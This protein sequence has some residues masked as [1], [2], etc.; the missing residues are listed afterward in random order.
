MIK[1]FLLPT[2]LALLS[3]SSNIYANECPAGGVV[4]YRFN[5]LDTTHE[6]FN[7][8]LG[9]KLPANKQ[10][11][12]YNYAEMTSGFDLR[13]TLRIENLAELNQYY[14]DNFHDTDKKY[15]KISGHI[16]AVSDFPLNCSQGT[17]GMA[18]RFVGTYG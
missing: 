2:L 18:D 9:D 5:N 17:G 10:V 12:L 11:I 14:F 4:V 1:K 13:G 3:F 16:C 6:Q 15:N 8:A 7:C